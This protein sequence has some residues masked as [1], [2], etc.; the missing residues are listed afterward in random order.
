VALFPGASMEARATDQRGRLQTLPGLR[1]LA[2]ERFRE[3]VAAVLWIIGVLLLALYMIRATGAGASQ[4]AI[5]F[6]AYHAAAQAMVVDASPYAPVMLQGPI[7]AQGV[8]AYRYPPLLAQAL[9]PM[10]MLPLP[11]AAVVWAILQGA[12]VFAATWLALGAGGARPTRERFLWAGVA[13]TYFLPVFDSLW[14]G[15][16]GGFLALT[17]AVALAAPGRRGSADE[18][19]PRGMPLL[20]T[21]SGIAIAVAMLVKLTPG[22]LL[23]PAA[24]AALRGLRHGRTTLLAAAASTSVLLLPSIAL[25]PDA[26]REYATVLPNLLA[27][28]AD[29]PTNLAPSSLAAVY[30]PA[31]TWLAPLAR[32]A[33]LAGGLG[34]LALSFAWARQRDTLAAAVTAAVAG[35]LL[36]PG[37]AWYHYLAVLLP[38]AAFAWP[39][40]T[41]VQRAAMLAGSALVYT[42]FGWFLPLALP[43]AAI[44]VGA[45]LIT[46]RHGAPRPAASPAATAT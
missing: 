20:G 11:A 40:A 31:A 15:N 2:S 42:G 5:D 10:A 23:L 7:P 32:F 30:L 24:S 18:V 39:R 12:A 33:A 13:T 6:A 36:L 35:S 19:T 8:G 46:L 43:G 27:G 37:A 4:A 26:W 28:P 22:V 25:A 16:V 38:P 9:G 29:Y 41:T 1:T 3:L 45:V 14:K 34:L 17:V 44:L 21:L